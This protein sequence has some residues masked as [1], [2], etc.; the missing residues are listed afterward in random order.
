[1]ALSRVSSNMLSGDSFQG[2]E[3]TQ[4]TVNNTS[5]GWSSGS[6]TVTIDGNGST[7]TSGVTGFVQVPYN[8]TIN[9]WDIIADQSG[10]ISVDVLSG[11]YG[12][13]PPT[14]TIAGSEKPALSTALKNQDTNLTTWTTDLLTGDYLAFYVE[15]SPAPA[16]VTQVVITL[17]VTKT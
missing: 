16:S 12:N 9:S 2:W 14:A 11:V 8:C 10:T 6:I 1:M 17:D 5:G 13:Y 3:S 7:I 4:T 15:P